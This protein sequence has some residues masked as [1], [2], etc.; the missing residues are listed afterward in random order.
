M[1]VKKMSKFLFSYPGNAALWLNLCL[2]LNNL[3]SLAPKEYTKCA[4]ATAYHANCAISLGRGK[5]DIS[6]V[7]QINIYMIVE[8]MWPA[9][10]GGGNYIEL[11]YIE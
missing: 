10:L 5:I 9:F 3:A 8:K 1:A 7:I 2:L 6:K 4:A 11:L